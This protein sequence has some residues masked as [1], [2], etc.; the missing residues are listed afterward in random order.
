MPHRRIPSLQA[1]WFFQFSRRTLSTAITEWLHRRKEAIG[2][3]MR[4][5]QN[6]FVAAI[7][8]VVRYVRK[9]SIA[10]DQADFKR[11]LERIIEVPSLDAQVLFHF[12]AGAGA[13][14]LNLHAGFNW[15]PD[16]R[17]S[18]TVFTDGISVHIDRNFSTRQRVKCTKV[19]CPNS[20]EGKKSSNLYCSD[21]CADYVTTNKRRSKIRLLKQAE[22]VWMKLPWSSR[23]NEDHWEWIVKWI[24]LRSKGAFKIELI[25]GQE[26]TYE[27]ESG[28]HP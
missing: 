25:W 15:G 27:S 12:V 14:A 2:I 5:E 16:G 28:D 24:R 17:P 3:L 21:R 23:R 20:F 10:T 8:V 19:G 6:V 7:D 22:R 4:V 26:R 11:A 13:A 18:V 9:A 1:R